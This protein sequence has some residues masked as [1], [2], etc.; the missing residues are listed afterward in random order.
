MPQKKQHR[1]NLYGDVVPTPLAGSKAYLKGIGDCP[2]SSQDSAIV[3]SMSM[4]I[5]MTIAKNYN[6]QAFGLS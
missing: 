5:D 1:D 6:R 4:L 2:S 3:M